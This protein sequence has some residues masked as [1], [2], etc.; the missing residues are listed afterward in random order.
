MLPTRASTSV[1]SD[2]PWLIFP[3]EDGTALFAAD[4]DS[5]MVRKLDLP[6]PLIAADLPA[7]VSPDGNTLLVRGGNTQTESEFALFKVSGTNLAV[8]KLT[9][10]V[11]SGVQKDTL[12]VN[13][14]QAIYAMQAVMSPHGISWNPKDGGAAFQMA[15]DGDA[16]NL[17]RF[18]P[19]TQKID[20]IT[21]RYQQDLAPLWSPGGQ[22]LVFQEADTR[23]NPY[24]WKVSLVG[25]MSMN[26]LERVN[27]LYLPPESSLEEVYAGWLNESRL[28]IFTRTETGNSTLRLLNVNGGAFTTLFAGSFDSVALNTTDGSIALLIGEKSAKKNMQE[29]GIYVRSAGSTNFTQVLLGSYQWLGFDASLKSFLA[30]NDS[31][32]VIFNT[33]GTTLSI[34]GAQRLSVSPDGQWLISWSN[35]GTKLHTAD[36]TFL[37]QVSE[38]QVENLIWQADSYGIFYLQ[39]DGL[40]H[41]H[42]PRLDPIKLTDD[43][44]HQNGGLFNWLGNN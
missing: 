32:V 17:F 28:L 31:G 13:N 19:A 9:S 12:N 20:R 14:R 43:V 7:A 21:S 3:N 29:P 44:Y 5:H 22:I 23:N 39:A 24:G 6:S 37:Q 10:L 27:Y 35:T 36:G 34:P 2:G 16:T 26:D 42:F 8:Q 33:N 11:S 30:A 4:R 38:D 1:P 41:S 25:S 40:Y 15:V 18:N